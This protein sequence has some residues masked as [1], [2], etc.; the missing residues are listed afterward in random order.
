MFLLAAFKTGTDGTSFAG[1]AKIKDETSKLYRQ[2][3]PN[4]TAG[5][6]SHKQTFNLPFYFP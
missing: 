2:W 5:I 6:L 3:I 1:S 4:T